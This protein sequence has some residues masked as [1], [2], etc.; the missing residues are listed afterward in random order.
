MISIP[1]TSNGR[2]PES[3][4]LHQQLQEFLAVIDVPALAADIAVGLGIG[5][6]EAQKR[7]VRYMNETA[8]SLRV[9]EPYL[10]PDRRILEVG[11]GTGL[12][13]LFLRGAGYD[14]TAIEPVGPG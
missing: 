2:R 11:S 7:L 12:F 3:G 13:S 8:F 9:V 4:L 10:R 14:V 5:S 1:S 6:V